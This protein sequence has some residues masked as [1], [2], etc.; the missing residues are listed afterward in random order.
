MVPGGGVES[1]IP[2]T[3]HKLLIPDSTK[4]SKPTE[5]TH[6]GTHWA[7]FG[8]NDVSA[9]TPSPL[10]GGE[11]P[12]RL[13]FVPDAGCNSSETVPDGRDSFVFQNKSGK[14]VEKASF[15][16]Q[17]FRC[18]RKIILQVPRGASDLP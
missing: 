12:Y 9:N 10:M 11:T 5:P 2:L 14:D 17:G 13:L 6:L 1:H 8:H 3:T 7:Q 16:Q 18:G 4:T 15:R